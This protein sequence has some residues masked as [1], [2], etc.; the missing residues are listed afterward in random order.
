MAMANWQSQE[1]VMDEAGTGYLNL[2]YHGTM[3]FTKTITIPANSVADTYLRANLGWGYDPNDP[4]I[5]SWTWGNVVDQAIHLD[6]KTPEIEDIEILDQYC[7]FS[8]LSR[9][10]Q[11]TTK[12]VWFRAKLN[13]MSGYD[14][15]KVAW[16]GDVPSGEGNPYQVKPAA[17]ITGR[18]KT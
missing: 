13:N 15:V 1:M 10:M 16:A 3:T 5:T 8:T 11:T 4:C 17:G 2:S 6:T 18:I 12:D 14:E 7:S 9:R